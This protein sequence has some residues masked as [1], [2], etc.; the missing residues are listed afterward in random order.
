MN[1]VDL[2]QFVISREEWEQ[3]KN[4][5]VDTS[6]APIVHF[7]IIIAISQKT[8]RWSVPTC[9]YVLSKGR[10]RVDT[11][12]RSEV[13]KFDLVIFDKDIFSMERS[14]K[15]KWIGLSKRLLLTV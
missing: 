5:E 14:I 2:V 3:C 15:V 13:C 8:F 9:R 1:F 12:T 7:V 11:T 6:D 4:F 10:L